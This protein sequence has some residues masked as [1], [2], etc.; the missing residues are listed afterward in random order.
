MQTV[1]KGEHAVR[2]LDV[3]KPKNHPNISDKPL[4]KHTYG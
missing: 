1:L 3:N 2:Y 4:A